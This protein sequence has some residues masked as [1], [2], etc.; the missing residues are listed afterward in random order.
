MYQNL[1]RILDATAA[2]LVLLIASPLM[3]VIAAAI[4][5]NMGTPVLFRQWRPGLNERLFPCLKFR[6]MTNDRDANGY[7]LS[8]DSRITHL[9]RFLRRTSLDELPQ[10]WNIV[11]SD[12][13]F[14]GPR[15]LLEEYIP[16]YTP[17]ERRR[18]SLRPGLTGWAQVNG[19]NSVLFD[20]RLAMDTWYVD[21]VSFTLDLHIL[22]RTVWLVI[23]QKGAEPDAQSAIVRRLDIQ[24]SCLKSSATRTG[25]M[26]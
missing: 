11:R 15:P 3:L 10:L 26:R 18:H 17:E 5:L 23:T 25:N 22:V 19:R 12:L 6:T 7:L 16:Y 1:K 14:V 13:S 21:H 24:R 20:Q 8:D 2:A 9:G 4:R